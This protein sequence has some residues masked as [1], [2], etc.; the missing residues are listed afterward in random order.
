[1]FTSSLA[2]RSDKAIRGYI[3]DVCWMVL[4]FPSQLEMSDINATRLPGPWTLSYIG[5]DVNHTL[6]RGEW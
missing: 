1:M 6:T 5:D 4:Y 3:K 2:D